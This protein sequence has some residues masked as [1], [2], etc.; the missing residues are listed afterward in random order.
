MPKYSKQNKLGSSGSTCS[1]PEKAIF[2]KRYLLLLFFKI[3]RLKGVPLPAKNLCEEI[4]SA[5]PIEH[6]H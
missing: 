3:L 4:L 2:F 6:K 5:Y 1:A